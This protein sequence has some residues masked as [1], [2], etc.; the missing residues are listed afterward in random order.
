M[1]I[2]QETPYKIAVLGATGSGK[3]YFFSSY[4]YAT[5]CEGHYP[6]VLKK[7]SRKYIDDLRDALFG[8]IYTGTS[9]WQDMSIKVEDV[10]GDATVEFYDLP[11]EYT[12]NPEHE[13]FSTVENFLM[14]STG[15]LIFLP[16]D[17]AWYGIEKG[18]DFDRTVQI[19]TRLLKTLARGKKAQK[20]RAFDIPVYFI[21]TQA[22]RLKCTSLNGADLIDR[23]GDQGRDL[24]DLAK[25]LSGKFYKSFAVQ[26]LGKWG[27]SDQ[28]TPP[29]SQNYA[30][31][32]VIESMES[33]FV[34]M[35]KARKNAAS[36]FKGVKKNFK[37]LAGGFIS[38]WLLHVLLN[39]RF[40]G[41]FMKKRLFFLKNLAERIPF[42]KS[43]TR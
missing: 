37:L 40:Q 27:G 21:F 10:L 39:R 11:G 31:V 6:T 7:R 38:G 8:P 15:V 22:D 34:D 1:N 14:Q 42:K 43:K 5:E 4:F 16:A 13:E 24:Q 17:K 32:N 25:E 23:M 20:K 9:G 12:V 19:Y 33:M 2:D 35:M 36:S 26:A 18:S 41:G 3:T 30:P 28:N 29:S